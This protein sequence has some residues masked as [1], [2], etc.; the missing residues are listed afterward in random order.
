M[1]GSLLH[2]IIPQFRPTFWYGNRYSSKSLRTLARSFLEKLFSMSLFTGPSPGTIKPSLD[3][4]QYML[5][6][7]A[8][9]P[10]CTICLKSPNCLARLRSSWSCG[11]GIACALV[12]DKDI[13]HVTMWTIGRSLIF[14]TQ[15]IAVYHLT[16]PEKTHCCWWISCLR[17][18]D[19]DWASV[20]GRGQESATAQQPAFRLT[21][22]GMP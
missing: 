8:I 4:T 10:N 21:S 9:A 3:I 13:A 14:F 12:A 17:E 5:I 19:D 1:P 6:E 15:A 22:S 2:S 16:L 18:C 11:G 7:P 20:L